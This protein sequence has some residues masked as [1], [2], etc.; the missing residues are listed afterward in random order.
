MNT[1]AFSINAR[2]RARRS[3]VQAIYQWLLAKQPI[4]EVIKEF[5]EDRSE[6]KKADKVYFQEIINGVVQHVEEI[7]TVLIPL[8]D[9]PLQELDPV[10]RSILY[11]GVYELIYHPELPWKVVLNES[12]ELA[13]MFGAEKSHKYIN[14]IL[15]KAA[16]KL[17]HVEVALNN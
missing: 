17:R 5:Q 7:T 16:Q 2:I 3:A 4:A 13:K 12:I 15:D 8:L 1:P 6:L 14:G 9:R 11:L 10:E